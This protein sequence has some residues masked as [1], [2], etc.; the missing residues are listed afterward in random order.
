MQSDAKTV[1]EYLAGLPDVR[2]KAIKTLRAVIRK[3]LPTGYEE[4]INWGMITY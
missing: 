1:A 4:A 2:R 3:H